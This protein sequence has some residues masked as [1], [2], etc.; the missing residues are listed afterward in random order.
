MTRLLSLVAL[1]AVLLAAPGCMSSASMN[2]DADLGGAS[3]GV[4]VGGEMMLPSRTL[5]D[6]ASRASNLTTL[7]SAVQAADLVE[8]LAGPGPFTVFA[9]TNSAFAAV[10]AATLNSLLEPAN[11]AQLQAVLTYHVVAG[12]LSAAD[13]RD[14]QMLTT[15]N[16]AQL[17]VTKRDGMVMVGG[18]TVTQANVYASNGVAHVIDTVLV[19]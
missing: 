1:S 12:R 11:K 5:P 10:P 14:G 16:G 13:L 17:R 8:T 3:A 18:A 15:V 19:P 9:P 4:M 7:V 2:A 6:N